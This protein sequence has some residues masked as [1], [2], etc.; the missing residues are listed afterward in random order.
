MN[1]ALVPKPTKKRLDERRPEHRGELQALDRDRLVQP[2]VVPAVD[3][4]EPPLA[5]ELVD[6]KLAVE[7][8]ADQAEG[9]Q[10]IHARHITSETFAF[11]APSLPPVEREAHAEHPRAARDRLRED[12]VVLEGGAESAVSAEEVEDRELVHPADADDRLDPVRLGVAAAFDVERDA[13]MPKFPNK[14]RFF[15]V[16][17]T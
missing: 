1:P 2:G 13:A 3:D 15:R 7:D 11:R 17:N 5:D 4:A 16:G 9:V 10:R 6:A 8:L 14:P 12:G